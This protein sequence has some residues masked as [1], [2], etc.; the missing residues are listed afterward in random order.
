MVIMT[1]PAPWNVGP[2]LFFGPCFYNLIVAVRS[3]SETQIERDNSVF[4]GL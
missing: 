1:F 2:R 4:V 3:V